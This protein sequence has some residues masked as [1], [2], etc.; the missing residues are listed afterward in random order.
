[1]R[2]KWDRSSGCPTHY[3]AL[4]VVR[5]PKTRLW[6]AVEETRDRGWWL[7]GGFV[8]NEDPGALSSHEVTALKETREE[9]GIDIVIKGILRVESHL[10]TQSGRH[11]VV[12]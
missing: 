8:E 5:H 3:F 2:A 4:A 11:R 1:M 7:P 10:G 12:F 9:A 6:L